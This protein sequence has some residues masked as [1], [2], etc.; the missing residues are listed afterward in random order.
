MPEQNEFNNTYHQQYLLKTNIKEKDILIAIIEQIIKNLSIEYI[1]ELTNKV[2]KI[3]L[4]LILKFNAEEFYKYNEDGEIK[5]EYT[6]N[7][8]QTCNI[9]AVNTQELLELDEFDEELFQCKKE[10]GIA[11]SYSIESK[12]TDEDIICNSSEQKKIFNDIQ[13]W[14]AQ[15]I[16]S[17]FIKEN[18][19][20]IYKQ[21]IRTNHSY[22]ESILLVELSNRIRNYAINKTPKISLHRTLLFY[23]EDHIICEFNLMYNYSNESIHYLYQEYNNNGI[24]N[25][26]NNL[27]F[28]LYNVKKSIVDN[29]NK[30]FE[31]ILTNNSAKII[32]EKLNSSKLELNSPRLKYTLVYSKAFVHININFIQEKDNLVYENLAKYERLDE[33]VIYIDLENYKNFLHNKIQNILIIL[34]KIIC[35]KKICSLQVYSKNNNKINEAAQIRISNEFLG[36]IQNNLTILNK[37]C[38]PYWM[39]NLNSKCFIN[40][41]KKLQNTTEKKLIYFGVNEKNN[42]DNNDKNYFT[43]VKKVINTNPICNTVVFYGCKKTELLQHQKLFKINKVLLQMYMAIFLKYFN[44]NAKEI[45]FSYQKIISF[46]VPGSFLLQKFNH[47]PRFIQSN[48]ISTIIGKNNNP[49]TTKIKNP[50][51]TNDNK[52]CNFSLNIFARCTKTNRVRPINPKNQT[53]KKTPSPS[54]FS[55]L[56]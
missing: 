4:G 17:R 3:I 10:E 27:I 25:N 50:K 6:Q 41:C 37:A 36:I 46:L 40:L 15:T 33:L 30:K 47:V 49:K 51:K 42:S 18:L 29:K 53:I 38:I 13:K 20:E 11:F 8:V 28:D 48:K 22:H 44:A 2:Q 52:C 56:N 32:K 16:D 45:I 54:S 35:E 21:K 7:D 14:L 43:Q 12:N 39:V 26:I 24:D 31:I 23:I 19:S 34:G 55:K 9:P 1:D 5:K